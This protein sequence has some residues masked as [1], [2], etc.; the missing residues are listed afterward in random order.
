MTKCTS[1]FNKHLNKC[2][3]KNIILFY[4]L[5][6]LEEIHVWLVK[7]FTGFISDFL[8]QRNNGA[9]TYVKFK[10][11]TIHHYKRHFH[12]NLHSFDTLLH[13]QLIS[14]NWLGEIVDAQM[15]L[16]LNQHTW[17]KS[18]LVNELCFLENQGRHGTQS[19]WSRSHSPFEG[20][21]SLFYK[22][23]FRY[24]FWSILT[25]NKELK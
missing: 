24:T 15:E 1:T 16:S 19:N 14:H 6:L 23:G 17:C 12:L 22:K 20:T 2:Y 13:V 25:K 21:F 7:D 9:D 5:C 8:S 3:K 4:S 18:L 10:V 11:C